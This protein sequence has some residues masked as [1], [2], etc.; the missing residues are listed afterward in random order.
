MSSTKKP[1]TPA[2]LSLSVQYAAKG[3]ALPSRA[4]L[5]KWVRA[6]RPGAA[7]VTVRFVDTEEGRVL[8]AQYRRKDHATNVLTFPYAR[9]PVLSGDLVLC[10]PLVLR[11]AAAQGKPAAAHFAHLV[12][13]GMLHLQGYD[14]ET[15]AEARIMEQ[16]EREILARLGYPDPY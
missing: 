13:H 11:E 9:E 8:N 14:H 12:V 16:K 6:T 5:R 3:E 2:R 1:A 15:A 7:E 10:L 4:E